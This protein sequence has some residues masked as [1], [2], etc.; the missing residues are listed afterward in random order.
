MAKE[1]DYSSKRMA[2]ADLLGP[3]KNGQVHVDKW[4]PKFHTFMAGLFGEYAD[5]FLD[6]A[7]RDYM[8]L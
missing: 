3:D 6:E 8:K 7:E 1:I 4:K 5:C 2:E